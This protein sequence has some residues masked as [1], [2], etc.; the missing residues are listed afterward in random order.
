MEKCPMARPEPLLVLGQQ[1]VEPF[2]DLRRVG[3]GQ[4]DAVG[5]GRAAPRRGRRARTSVSRPLMRTKHLLRPIAERPRGSCAPGSAPRPSRRAARRPRG[6]SSRRRP[7]RRGCSGASPA[8]CRGRRAASAAGAG[9]RSM[10]HSSSKNSVSTPPSFDRC[11]SMPSTTYSDEHDLAGGEDLGLD[12][13]AADDLAGGLGRR[14][15][16][17]GRRSVPPRSGTRLPSRPTRSSGPGRR[18]T[19]MRGSVIGRLAPVW[20][21]LNSTWRTDPTAETSGAVL[22]ARRAG[23]TSSNCSTSSR[24]GSIRMMKRRPWRHSLNDSLST[25]VLRRAPERGLDARLDRVVERAR[26]R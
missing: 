4:P 21:S 13:V 2:D 3:L 5:T 7:R 20:M 11:R 23:R 19:G 22:E 10:A 17:G 24:P 15:R 14:G 25:S 9:R 12:Q 8:C 1:R 16:G 18:C 26:G 6:R